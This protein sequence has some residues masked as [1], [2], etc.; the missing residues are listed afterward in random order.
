[1]G[2]LLYVCPDCGGW[3]IFQSFSEM[4]RLSGG[5]GFVACVRG[6][7]LMIQVLKK[8]K[9]KVEYANQLKGESS[10]VVSIHR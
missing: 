7:G 8:D 9:L 6:C 5:L 3:H 10:H 1:M 4:L 2:N